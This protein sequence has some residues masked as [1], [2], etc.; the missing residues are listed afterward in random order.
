LIIQMIDILLQW[1]KDE[2]TR[3]EPAVE[4]QVLPR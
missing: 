1:F 2:R 3:R 4:L